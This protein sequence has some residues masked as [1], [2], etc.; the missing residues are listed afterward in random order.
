[1]I[2]VPSPSH[3]EYGEGCGL[4]IQLIPQH[5]QQELAHSRCSLELRAD[6]S[7]TRTCSKCH[8][9]TVPYHIPQAWAEPTMAKEL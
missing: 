1:M 5:L 9:C 7:D 6:I 3:H 8:H 2:T 4:E